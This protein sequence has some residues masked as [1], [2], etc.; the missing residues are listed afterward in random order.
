MAMIGSYKA[1]AYWS[2]L[3]NY[4]AGTKIQGPRAIAKAIF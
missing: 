2:A 1:S 4:V 3:E